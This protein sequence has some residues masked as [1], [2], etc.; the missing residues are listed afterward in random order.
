M[1]AETAGTARAP[2]DPEQE[3]LLAEA[4]DWRFWSC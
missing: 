2:G 4:V 1:K 3:A